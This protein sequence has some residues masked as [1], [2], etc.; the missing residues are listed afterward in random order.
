MAFENPGKTLMD[1]VF[2]GMAMIWN[3]AL[4]YAKIA[5]HLMRYNIK[6][7]TVYK[8]LHMDS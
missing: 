8:K 3:D 7:R 6:R 1:S 2:I 4:T 5:I